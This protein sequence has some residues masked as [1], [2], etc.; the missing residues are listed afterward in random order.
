MASLDRRAGVLTVSDRVSGGEADDASGP[1][2]AEGLAGLGW[3]VAARHAVPDDRDAIERALVRWSDE[4]RLPLVVTTGGTGVAPRDV[5]PDAT[6]AVVDREVSG[7]GE[8]LRAA[9]LAKTPH[10]MLSRAVAGIRGSTL[11]VNLPGSPRAVVEQLAVLAP[12]LD[13]AVALLG[14]RGDAEA[15]HRAADRAS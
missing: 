8:A 7:I 6:R 15:D 5:T 2:L 9:S 14:G 10:A 4:D 12:V 3:S 1:A 11:I 13:H